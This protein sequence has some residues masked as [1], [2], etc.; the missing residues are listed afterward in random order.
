M[1]AS[2]ETAAT[3]KKAKLTVSTLSGDYTHEFP[4]HQKLQVVVDQTV[5]HLHLVAEGEWVLEHNGT[6]LQLDQTIE[7]TGL[8]DGDVLTLSSEEGGGGSERQ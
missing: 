3:D 6:Q 4:V 7:Q 5:A 1:T 8:K 2:Q